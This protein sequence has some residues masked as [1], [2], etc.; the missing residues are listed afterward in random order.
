MSSGITAISGKQ[1]VDLAAHVVGRTPAQATTPYAPQPTALN[2]AQMAPNPS[3]RID[4]AL[5]LVVMEFHGSDGKVEN[6]IPT[7][8]QL[9]AYRRSQ[10][11]ERSGTSYIAT[12]QPAAPSA[13]A[14][15]Q[16][17]AEQRQAPAT[18]ILA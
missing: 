8:Q 9:D 4:S 5:S 13:A 16:A 12:A 11:A 1:A 18:P 14:G 6:S 15:D 10:G 2:A 17:V 3:M 7:P